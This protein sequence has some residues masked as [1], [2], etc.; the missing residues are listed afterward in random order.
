VP[1]SE[2]VNRKNDPIDIPSATYPICIIRNQVEMFPLSL[3]PLK[4][5]YLK[6]PA[7]M[8]WGYDDSGDDLVYNAGTSTQ[9]DWPA[10]AHVDLI[11]RA[12]VFLGIPLDQQMMIKLKGYEKQVENV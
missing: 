8:V 12:C 1:E 3:T 11:C 2:W 4:L 5:Y 9:P 10:S 7:V 6:K